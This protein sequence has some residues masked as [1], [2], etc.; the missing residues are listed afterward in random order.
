MTQRV[1][2]KH[3]GLATT[4]QSGTGI[5]IPRGG[6]G[7]GGEYGE[8]INDTLRTFAILREPVAYRTVFSIAKAI[9]DNWFTLEGS[10]YRTPTQ[11]APTEGASEKDNSAFDKRIQKQLD[12]IN[13]KQE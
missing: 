4:T 7:G 9:F 12:K 1:S 13:A 6:T 2:V 11:A 5:T 8:E 3:V 10:N